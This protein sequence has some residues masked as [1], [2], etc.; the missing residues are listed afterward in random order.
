MKKLK[1]ALLSTAILVGV[2]H[3][4]LA[5]Y[6]QNDLDT[7]RELSETEDTQ[8]LLAFIR[9]NPQLMAGET[10]LADALRDFVEAR[11][12]GFM[13]RI[14]APRVPDMAK[15]PDLPDAAST[16]AQVDFGSLG[17]FGS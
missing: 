3:A 2:N 13:G 7:L 8:A 17:D 14:F 9:A 10:P 15:V 4:S 5:A 6:T 12:G 16:S 11:S 1:I